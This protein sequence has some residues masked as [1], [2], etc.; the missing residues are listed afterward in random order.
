MGVVIL[1]LFKAP[2]RLAPCRQ[3]SSVL[4]TDRCGKGCSGLQ[5]MSPCAGF[6]LQDHE[7]YAMGMRL[8]I[9]P[10]DALHWANK[11][12]N[13]FLYMLID[14]GR[15][16]LIHNAKRGHIKKKQK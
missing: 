8:E 1:S 16:R 7:N 3:E 4:E 14:M 11:K 15:M 13:K 9:W 6:A 12:H 5:E 2:Q 10:L